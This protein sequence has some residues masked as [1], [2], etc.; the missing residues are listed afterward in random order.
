MTKLREQDIMCA[1][2]LTDAGQSIRGTAQQL[3]VAEST[4]RYRLHRRRQQAIDG[5]SQQTEKCALFDDLIQ[6]WIAT[7]A[8]GEGRPDS[9]QS[10][11]EQLTSQHGFTGSYKAV[12]RYVRRRRKPPKIRPKRRVETRPG[13]Q[14]QLD[15]A[16][17][18]LYVEELG[19]WTCLSAFL[20]SLSYSRM[21]SVQWSVDQTQLAWMSCHTQAFQWLGGIPWSVRIDNLK[22]AVAQGGGPWA[23][24]NASY[25]SYADQVGFVVDC[26]RIRQASDKGKVERRVRD[27]KSALIRSQERFDSLASLQQTTDARI[28][29]RADRLVCPVTGESIAHSW[30]EE[31]AHL[32]PLPVTWPTPFDVQVSRPVGRDGLVHFENR[33]YAVPFPFVGRTVEVRGCPQT[34][35]IYGD[36]QLLISYPR[37]TQSRLL[38][39][40]ACYEG[41]ATDRVDRPTPLGKIGQTVVLER[42]WEAPQRPMAMYAHLVDQAARRPS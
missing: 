14:A 16:T 32:Y 22:T 25:T 4:L 20:M 37:H 34:V 9:V 39:D 36:H 40:Q 42:S 23:V 30:Q 8:E 24:L 38:I 6:A 28:R 26:C 5:R 27:V 18:Q 2:I 41:D 17:T 33:Q 7:Q 29:E 35:E 1:E 11:Y 19:G 15:W 12:W 10:L 3:G 31:Q 13:T 21:W